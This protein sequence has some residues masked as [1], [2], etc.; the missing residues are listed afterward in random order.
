MVG[1]LRSV[2]EGKLKLVLRVPGTERGRS[3]EERKEK[4]IRHFIQTSPYASWEWIGGRLLLYEED[5]AMQ[6]VKEHIK[7]EE[8]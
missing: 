1:A 5:M 2:D 8:G 6:V 3:E 7:P 4:I